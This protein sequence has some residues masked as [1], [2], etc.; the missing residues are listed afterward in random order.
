MDQVDT[1]SEASDS[2]MIVCWREIL[3]RAVRVCLLDDVASSATD[4]ILLRFGTQRI[5]YPIER[6]SDGIFVSGP[7]EDK[8]MVTPLELKITND[9]GILAMDV[10]FFWSLWT[11]PHWKGF[12]QACDALKRLEDA[13]WNCVFGSMEV[14]V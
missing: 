5:E 2:N 14:G 8:S 12:Q 13:G 3:V 9:N 6:T 4:R 7:L 1:E 10:Q 11:D